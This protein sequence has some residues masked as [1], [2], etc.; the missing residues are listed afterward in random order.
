MALYALLLRCYVPHVLR[1]AVHVTHI[2][3]LALRAAEHTVMR[4][5]SPAFASLPA[6]NT[7]LSSSSF[8]K[9]SPY[10]ASSLTIACQVVDGPGL[11]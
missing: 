8:R 6:S 7:V 11:K 5:K 2:R 9:P 1:N 3:T 10:F 4:V